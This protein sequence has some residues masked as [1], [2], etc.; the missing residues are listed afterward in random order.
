MDFDIDEFLPVAP[1]P[2]KPLPPQGMTMR[3]YQTATVESIEQ[4]WRDGLRSQLAVLATGGGKTV[5][6]SEVAKRE[7]LLGHKVLIL[8]HSDELIEQARDKFQRSSGLKAAK[9]KAQDYARR[10]DDVVVASVQTLCRDARLKTWP[11]DHFQLI[12][13][14]EAHRSLAESY[15]KILNHFTGRILGV[16][17]TAD[18]GDKRALGE[19]YQRIAYDYGILQAVR[20]GWL[21]RP[22]VQTVPLE[23]DLRG[24]HVSN[25]GEG[26]DLDRREVSERIKPFLGTIAAKIREFAANRKI[27]CFLPSVETARDLALALQA[28]GFTADYVSGACTDRD[29]KVLRYKRGEIQALCNMALLCLDLET[30]ILTERGWLR[31]DEITMDDRVANWNFDGSVFFAEPLEIVHRDTVPGERMVSIDSRTLNLRV[32]ETHRMIVGCKTKT[33]VWKKIPARDLG[34]HKLPAYG[35]AEPR[36]FTQDEMPTVPTRKPEKRIISANA[37]C[38]R[39]ATGVSFE[40]SVAEAKRRMD[41]RNGLRRKL[42]CE[43][44]VDECRFI[45]FWVADGSRSLLQSGGIEYTLCQSSVYPVIVAWVDR[46]IS[47]MGV[48]S[49]KRR[50]SSSGQNTS[51]Y[52]VWSLPRGTGGGSQERT[53]LF[54]IEHFLEKRGTPFIWGLDETQFDALVEGY[55]MGDGKHGD[56]ASLPR[57]LKFSDTKKEWIDLLCAVGS[58]RNWR[59]SISRKLMPN[60]NHLTQWGL[61]MVK[62]RN[63]VI[64]YRTP[65]KVEPDVPVPVW[66]VR[67]TSKNII[68]RRDGHVTVMGNTE[69]F[70][71]DEIDCIV[72]LRPTKI[73]ALY[74][75]IVGRGT[76]PLTEIVGML[77]LAT[78]AE[79]RRAIIAASAKPHLTLLDFLW[80]YEKHDLIRP[81]SLIAKS[82]EEAELMAGMGDGDLLEQ[83]ERAERDLLAKLEAE[84]RK[85]ARRTAKRIDPLTCVEELGDPSL[86]DYEPQ[87]AREADS[88]SDKQVKF[89]ASQGIDV[90]KVQ[91]KGLASAL[92]SRILTRYKSGLCT[93]RQ[94]HFFS[95]LGIDASLY[96]REEATKLMSEKIAAW[97]TRSATVRNT[98]DE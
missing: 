71:H 77:S 35:L 95:Q 70:D 7:V 90:S 5:I 36:K 40:E 52:Y 60:P 18:R 50:K 82:R 86:I 83:E 84:V 67:T 85:N 48:Y 30:E 88:P 98:G 94:L 64:S 28:V 96:T 43:L 89:L 27:L 3:P 74:T 42:P 59:C 23:L 45:G 44:T 62:R 63:L 80:L 53:G 49:I 6:F 9:E 32:T 34:L 81:A 69:G 41:R 46:V 25:T 37:Y 72:C 75:Q 38:I 8:A 76:R 91:S 65:I 21:V 58:V 54:H 24:V 17:A 73:R 61:N 15:L 13:V 87:S 33:A 14:D 78:S 39:K 31:H 66:C 11:P 1:A 47:N 2:A 4:G 97:R 19:V 56:G 26:R 55:W 68:T 29:E 92:T 20:D 93:M 12:I 22:V 57:S 16:T 79:E 51:D 10:W